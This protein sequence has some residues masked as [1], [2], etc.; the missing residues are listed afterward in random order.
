MYGGS[1]ECLEIPYS[2]PDTPL[3]KR[4]KLRAY[5]AQELGGLI[6]AYL[7]EEP[8]P[9]LPRYEFLVGPQY[10][11]DV[12]ISILPCSWLQIAENNMDPYHVEFLHFEF[13]NYVHKKIGKPPIEVRRHK[14]VDFELFEYGIIKRRLWEGESEETSEEWKVGHPQIWPGTA[15]V[16]YPNGWVQAQIRVP[17][18]DTET[19]IYWYNSRVRPEGAEPKA[20]CPVW[21]NPNITPEG[22]YVVDTLNGQDMAAMVTQGEVAD[23]SLENLN[24]TDRGIVMY[25]RALLNQLDRIA[26][27]KDPMGVVRDEAQNTPFI[28]LP[29]ESDVGYSLA[30]VSS[31]QGV[32]WDDDA[33]RA[34]GEAA[35]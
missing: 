29:I 33:S 11:H 22:G 34:A 3:K 19:A 2:R 7:G 16:P 25:R 15:V 9:L 13:S 8:A 14:K 20:E 31:A 5:P 23:R 35:E 1:G 21:D 12:G 18:S 28:K 26:E 6:W 10:D 27:G 24:E 4:A 30:G 32:N 17:M